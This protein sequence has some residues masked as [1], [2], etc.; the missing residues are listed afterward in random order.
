MSRQSS[1]GNPYHYPKGHP[2]GGQFAPKGYAQAAMSVC[3]HYFANRADFE[4]YGNMDEECSR[5]YNEERTKSRFLGG[6]ATE[7][8]KKLA[9]QIEKKLGTPMPEGGSAREYEDYINRNIREYGMASEDQAR[10]I[11]KLEDTHGIVL[12][13]DDRYGSSAGSFIGHCRNAE[14]CLDERNW[15]K[16]ADGCYYCRRLLYNDDGTP[17]LRKDGKQKS[18]KVGYRLR[19]VR[20]NGHTRYV[21]ER[22]IKAG[23]ETVDGKKVKIYKWRAID[24][25]G[26]GLKGVVKDD[27]KA[28]MKRASLNELRRHTGRVPTKRAPEKQRETVAAFERMASRDA[29]EQKDGGYE[30][31]NSYD[32]NN[33]YNYR[34]EQGTTGLHVYRDVTTVRTSREFDSDSG[35]MVTKS[36]KSTRREWVATGCQ[37]V[38]E[39]IHQTRVHEAGLITSQRINSKAASDKEIEKWKAQGRIKSKN[40]Y[41]HILDPVKNFLKAN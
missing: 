2:K 16:G 15:S 19:P 4:A 33:S 14:A 7:G 36:Y 1:R 28:G 9:T 34:I 12:A 38:D 31:S 8:Q 13:P 11:K 18:E 22:E 26:T 24:N 37:S 6:E 27:R 41:M 21:V 23:E 25:D 39:A 35:R 5:Y 32:S 17:A 20:E 40:E 30:F 29:W 10:Y 3:G